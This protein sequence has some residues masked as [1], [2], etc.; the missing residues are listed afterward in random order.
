MN[1]KMIEDLKNELIRLRNEN[2]E[3]KNSLRGLKMDINNQDDTILNLSYTITELR[4]KIKYMN[5]E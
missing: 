2:A 3:I 1:D 4:E 5:T